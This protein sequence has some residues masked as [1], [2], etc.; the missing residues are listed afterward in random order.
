MSIHEVAKQLNISET[1]VFN[2]IYK[3]KEIGEFFDKKCTGRAQKLD[4]RDQRH[5]KRLVNGENRLSINKSTRDMN[6]SLFEP[7]TSR[8]LQLS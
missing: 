8:S 5:L 4:E 3:H 1:S 7:I 6:Q 2:I